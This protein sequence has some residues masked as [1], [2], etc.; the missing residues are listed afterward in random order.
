VCYIVHND[1]DQCCGSGAFVPPWIRDNFFSDPQS[2]IPDLAPKSIRSKNKVSVY[3]TFHVGSGIQEKMFVSGFGIRDEKIV[4]SGILDITF[5]IRDTDH[6]TDKCLW[7][8]S[9]V[10]CC[11][12]G[13]RGVYLLRPV[14][15]RM[16]SLQVQGNKSR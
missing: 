10:C 2:R 13:P 9:V 7:T 4:G 12:C 8:M 11:L 16:F 3:S 5:R 1:Y 15:H 6:G 14:D